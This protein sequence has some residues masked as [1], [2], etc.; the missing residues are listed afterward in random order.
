MI[1]VNPTLGR[2]EKHKRWLALLCSFFIVLFCAKT[3]EILLLTNPCPI[4]FVH[5]FITVTAALM[6]A[7]FLIFVNMA[8]RIR[9]G[10]RS[11]F[12]PALVFLILALLQFAVVGYLHSSSCVNP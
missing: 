6:G 4:K 11:Y 10:D 2:K 3:T 1:Y 8:V 7:A 9:I 5:A 12:V